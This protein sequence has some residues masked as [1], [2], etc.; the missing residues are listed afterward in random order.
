MIKGY[1]DDEIVNKI[2]ELIKKL[3]V[4][5]LAKFIDFLDEYLTTKANGWI[6]ED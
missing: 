5:D 3:D 2:F 6:K 1:K 4:E